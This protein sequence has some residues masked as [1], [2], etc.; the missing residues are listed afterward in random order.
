MPIA[1]S[2]GSHEGVIVFISCR[3]TGFP[4]VCGPLVVEIDE[5]EHGILKAQTISGGDDVCLGT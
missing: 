3:L 4:V 2:Q 1:H 5:L